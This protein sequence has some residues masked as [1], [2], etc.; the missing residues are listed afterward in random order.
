MSKIQDRISG[1]IRTILSHLILREI[2]DPRLQ[3]ITV[4]DVEID[5]ELQ[6]ARIFVNA[7]GE[8]ERQQEVMK[9]LRHA[10]S[11]LRREVGSRMR[12]R[13]APELHF[14][15]DTSLERG[16]RL[17]RLIDHLDIPPEEKSDHADDE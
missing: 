3:H 15:W 1:R 2:S 17:N 4:T 8:E 16:E 13:K 11:Y 10:S 7:L 9:A 12:L 14:I 5:P 6:Y